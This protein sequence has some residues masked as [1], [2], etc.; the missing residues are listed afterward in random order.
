MSKKIA[1]SLL[2]ALTLSA[3]SSETLTLE[4]KVDMLEK[5]IQTLQLE[6][7]KKQHQ[8]H[9]SSFSQNAYLPDIALILNMSSVARN[10]N[11]TEYENFAIPGF[12]DK[13]EAEL[14]F[15]KNRGFNLNYAELALHSA[16]DPYFEAFAMLHLHPTQLEIGEAYIQT[17]SLPYGFAI[18]AGKFK[19]SFGR[20]NSK[21]QH[22]WSFDE[23]PVVYKAIFGPDC[24]SDNGIS[25]QWVAPT[26]TYIMVGIDLLQGSNERSFGDT[27]KNNLN[28]AY[29][30][31]SVDMTES[32]SALT[33][34]SFARGKN[35]L[36]DDTDIYN[37]ELTM[38]QQ[39]DSYSS[40]TWQSEAL[41][42]NKKGAPSDAKQAGFYTQLVYKY[43]K[44]YATG[45][46]Y[47]EIVKNSVDDLKKYTAMV[48]YHPFP[49]SRLRLSYSYDKTKLID[50]E[51]KNIQTMMLTLNIAA[52]AH[53]AHDY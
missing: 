48:E 24:L 31:T 12:I 46:R 32:L 52:G 6:S 51:R 22:A 14:P 39:L 20:I 53:G 29:I 5:K 4:Q 38:Q 7:A 50:S 2:C 35:T 11:N 47:D 28:V 45:V 17:T 1:L 25:T 49:M 41:Y 3:N 40:L 9:S 13:G 36:G 27:E 8:K 43:D 21:H 10:V 18:K 44:N 16:V 30:K 15:N 34:V 42:R 23:Q 33:G 26:D 37:A 19:S